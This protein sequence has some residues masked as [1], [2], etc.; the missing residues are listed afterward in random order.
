MYKVNEIFYSLQGE[1]CNVGTASV[2][3]RMSGCNLQCHFCDTRHEHGTMMTLQQI[4]DAVNQWPAAPLLVLTGGEPSLWIDEEFVYTLKSLTGKRIAIE[5]NGTRALPPGIDWVT[6]SPKTAYPGG[7]LMPCV[8]THCDELKVVYTG[9]DLE[10]YD[11][12]QATHRFLQPCYVDAP[13]ER[14]RNL[15]ACVQAVLAHPHW[16]LSLQ[17]HRMLGIR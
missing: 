17:T 9:Q 13:D 15:Q 14:Q 2:F 12:I 3:V 1:G 5:T 4:V 7:N 10:Q 11:H 6:F 8:L 16:R